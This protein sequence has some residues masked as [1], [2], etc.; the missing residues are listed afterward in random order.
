MSPKEKGFPNSLTNSIP[1]AQPGSQAK[2]KAKV[3]A[4]SELTNTVQNAPKAE[5]IE[6]TI[7][8]TTPESGSEATGQVVASMN[9]V[10]IASKHGTDKVDHGYQYMYEKYLP[11][12]RNKHVKMLEIGLGCNMVSLSFNC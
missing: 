5:S 8:E 10:E 3:K 6:Q 4:P 7:A 2:L 9:W 1:K 11:V 12:Y